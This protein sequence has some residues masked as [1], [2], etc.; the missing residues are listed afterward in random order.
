MKKSLILAVSAALAA[1]P[2]LLKAEPRERRSEAQDF[3]AQRRAETQAHYEQQRSENRAFQ[4]SLK[5]KTPE[6][7]QAAVQAHRETQHRENTAF[8]AEQT[9]KRRVFLTQSLAANT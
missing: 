1:A 5:D 6:E 2:L 8:A 3:R 9:E 7:K 4:E